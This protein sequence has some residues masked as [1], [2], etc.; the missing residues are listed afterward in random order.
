MQKRETDITQYDVGTSDAADAGFFTWDIP[1]NILYA[2]RALSVLFGIDPQ[3]AEH[4]LPLQHYLNRVHPEDRARL[5]KV[6][7]QSI[8]MHKS[9]NEIYRVMNQDGD[10]V[11]VM[12]FARGFRDRSGEPTRYVGMV[13]PYNAD[14]RQ[15][16][17]N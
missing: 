15:T 6:I 7:G 5:S 10:Y 17:L 16:L 12:S 13:I 2:D 11:T 14:V 8:L 1:E 4:G 3:L 9:Q